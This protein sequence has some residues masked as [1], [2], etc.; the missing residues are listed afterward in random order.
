M[1]C[2]IVCAAF[3]FASS[4]LA[5][6]FSP[7]CESS[8]IFDPSPSE[9]VV[10]TSHFL[11]VYLVA[12]PSDGASVSVC[13]CNAAVA[14]PLHDPVALCAPP[15]SLFLGLKSPGG[16]SICGPNLAGLV[17]GTR[18]SGFPFRVR[19]FH[20]R[21]RATAFLLSLSLSL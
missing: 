5:Y 3:V 20:Y 7:L 18:H 14:R 12:F 16:R 10:C 19:S 21:V 8:V 9:L 2:T 11:F 15:L 13:I 17:V 4:L 6:P 1:S